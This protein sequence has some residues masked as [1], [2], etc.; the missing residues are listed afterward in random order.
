MLGHGSTYRW[1]VRR[2]APAIE[3]ATCG[4]LGVVFMFKHPVLAGVANVRTHVDLGAVLAL[5]ALSQTTA[6]AVTSAM[7]SRDKGSEQRKVY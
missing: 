1:R 6:A 4:W 3:R 2:E 5:V 7:D